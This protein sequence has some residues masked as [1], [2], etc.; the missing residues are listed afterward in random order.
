MPL[1]SEEKNFCDHLD[2]ENTHVPSINGFPV[3][4]STWMT[5]HH[6]TQSCICNIL[7]L[8][9]VERGDPMLPEEPSEPF[10]PAWRT[11]GEARGRNVELAE[12]AKDARPDE[13]PASGK[14]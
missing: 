1:T 9:R 12:E 3:P 5:T 14:V 6:L 4:A 8:R 7:M 10:A 13:S 11:A 2:Y